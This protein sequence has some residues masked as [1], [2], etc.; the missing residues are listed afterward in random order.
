V[1]LVHEIGTFLF[2]CFERRIRRGF[3]WLLVASSPLVVIVWHLRHLRFFFVLLFFVLF[4]V[5]K[6]FQ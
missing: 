6:L 3:H 4:L 5:L 2:E 1:D